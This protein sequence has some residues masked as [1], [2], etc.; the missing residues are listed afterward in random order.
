MTPLPLRTRRLPPPAHIVWDD[1]ARPATTGPRVWL[2]LVDD[3]VPPRVLG[4]ERP[5]RLVWSSLWPSRPKDR[6]DFELT[7]DG[8]D[9]RVAITLLAAGDPPDDETL[10]HLRHRLSELLWRDLR[11]SYGQ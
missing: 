4:G 8:R 10:R 1:L 9:T 3:E 11:H 7:A 6:I 5:H 2:D